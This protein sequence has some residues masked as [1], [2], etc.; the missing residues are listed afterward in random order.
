[1]SLVRNLKKKEVCLEVP[2]E[3]KESK[4]KFRSYKT[5]REN[6]QKYIQTFNM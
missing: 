2:G 6:S 1:M 3:P 4:E 5:Y